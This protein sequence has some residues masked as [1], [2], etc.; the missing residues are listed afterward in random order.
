MTATPVLVVLGGLPGTGKTTL[1]RL[2][3]RDLGAA[4]LRIDTLEQAVVQSSLRV[5]AAAEVG[6]TA[7]AGVARDNLRLGLSVVAD[8]VNPVAESQA[9]WHAVAAAT[10]A[11]LVEI[12]LLCSDPA[13]H[14]RRVEDRVADIPGHVQPTWADVSTTE[15]APWPG[16][17]RLDSAHRAPADLALDARSVIDAGA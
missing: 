15:L 10:R 16:A 3:A 17:V 11:R 7:A 12:Q 6:Y 4:H 13:E 1:A 8:C 14:R 9:G 5:P 2:L